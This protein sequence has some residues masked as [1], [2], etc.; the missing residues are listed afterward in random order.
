MHYNYYDVHNYY[1]DTIYY[2]TVI[3][4]IIPFNAF[5]LTIL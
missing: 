2:L 1:H 5:I 3:K 4:T